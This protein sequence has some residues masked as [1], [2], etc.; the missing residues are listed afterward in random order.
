MDIAH[1]PLLKA[2]PRVEMAAICGRNRARAQEMADKYEVARVFTDYREMINQADLDAVVIATPDDQHYEMALAAIDAGLHVL[3]EKPLALNA[4]DAKAMYER[5]EAKGV[6]HMTFYT[7]RWMPHYRAMY[8]LIQAGA[9]G[10]IYHCQFNF[11]MGFGHNKEYQWRFDRRH[12]NGILG[13]SGSHMFDL[14]RYLV[15]DIARVSASLSSNVRHEVAPDGRPAE[16]ANDAALVLLQFENGAHGTV[17]LSAVARVDD[18]IFEQSIALHGEAGSLVAELR[19]GGTSSQLCMAR[20]DEP[21]MPVTIPERFLTGVDLQQPLVSQTLPMFIQQPI[22]CR[23][24]VD[25]IVENHPVVPSL[26]DGWKAQQVIDAA[27][28]ADESGQ[29]VATKAVAP[30]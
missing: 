24:F 12:A 11:L 7:W 25:G 26:Y 9:V 13:D 28:A 14:A 16:L 23:L 1:L 29:W 19:L 21:F 22:G 6:R 27:L 3:C 8:E 2:D 4:T 10:R 20:G 18:P 30:V 5:A 17:Q 15:G